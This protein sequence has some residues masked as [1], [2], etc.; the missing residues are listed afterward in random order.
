MGIGSIVQYAMLLKLS[1]QVDPSVQNAADATT[2][3]L[4]RVNSAANNL[5]GGM[6]TFVSGAAIASAVKKAFSFVDDIATQGNELANSAARLNTTTQALQGLDYAFGQSG[7]EDF[8]THLDYMNKQL[9]LAQ[10]GQGKAAKV[11]KEFGLDANKLARMAPDKAI[12]RIA[13]YMNAI[14]NESERARLAIALF[15]SEGADMARALGMGS[16]GIQA[17]RKEAEETGL[18]MSDQMIEMAKTYEAVKAKMQATMQG[19]KTQIFGPLMK[20]VTDIFERISPIIQSLAGTFSTAVAKIGAVLSVVASIIGTIFK[21][22][23]WVHDTL[24]RVVPFFL[25]FDKI[26]IVLG[27]VLTVISGFFIIKKLIVLWKTMTTAVRAFTTA[28]TGNPVLLALTVIAVVLSLIIAYWDDIK[29]AVIKVWDVIKNVFNKIKG[30]FT[31]VIDFFKNN[32]KTILLFILNPFAGAFKLLYTKC[33]GF[34]NFINNLIGKIK[35]IFTSVFQFIIKPYVMA[36]NFITGLWG[37]IVGFF[38][39]IGTS[40]GDAI[41]GAFK[42][43]VNGALNFIGR[44]VNNAVNGINMAIGVI[45]KIPGINIPLIPNWTVPQLA[46]GGLIKSPTLAM[47]GEAGREWAIPD[48]GSRRAYELWNAA[49]RQF[50]NSPRMT[51]PAGGNAGGVYVDY[52]PINNFY[53]TPAE[54]QRE[55]AVRQRRD[56]DDLESRLNEIMA[57]RRRLSFA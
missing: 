46:Y 10:G 3:Q 55:V 30:I 17:L 44:I 41:S 56:A 51:A 19:M 18:V 16:E 20:A 15:G 50:D 31:G 48:N 49:G 6:K 39:G 52:R 32:W 27:A 38:K 42:A 54:M 28:C 1:G 24:A 11:L 2:A 25:S 40:I 14:P 43:V 35:Q 22:L 9:V 21:W 37:K 53:G 45:N 13:D 7:I 29:G 33:E 47:I 8:T 23:L 5:F 4:N 57:N 26:A 34:R 36:W 12:E